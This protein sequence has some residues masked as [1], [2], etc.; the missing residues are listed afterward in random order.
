[1][2]VVY[3]SRHTSCP[4]YIG[5]TP[6]GFGL[7]QAEVGFR[8]HFNP[9][10]STILLVLEGRLRISGS[11][12]G[13][14][15][16]DKNEMYIVPLGMEHEVTALETTRALRLYLIGNKLEFCGRVMNEELILRAKTK[17]NK[18]T[19]LPLLPVIRKFAELMATYIQDGLLC[20]DIHKLKQQEFAALLQ[21]YYK[22]IVLSKFLVPLYATSNSF[23]EEV[24]T[25][26]AELL[27]VDEMAARLNMP[28]S[29]FVH[30]FALHFKEPHGKWLTRNKANALYKTLRSS[31]LSLSEI[32]R[33][34][35]FS[36]QQHM[37]TFC[38]IHLG[39][40]PRQ[41]I[42]GFIPTNLAEADVEE[43][44]Y[45]GL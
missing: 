44:S 12:L 1:M 26:A 9:H 35:R 17:R 4:L 37:N 16:V 3:L 45:P 33:L 18:P 24:M 23:M 8:G 42:E 21:A 14:Q 32:S 30:L 5:S 38:R 15:V 6:L 22:K 13:T 41:I 43:H 27:N 11:N 28:R 7:I 20:C 36:S 39:C 25:M 31:S 34:L 19:T 2:S 40:T 10:L 29:E